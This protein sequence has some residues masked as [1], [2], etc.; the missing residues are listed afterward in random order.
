M[1]TPAE[2]PGRWRARA[3]DLIPYSTAAVA[4]FNEVAD[5]LEKALKEQAAELLT[6]NEAAEASGFSAD[7]LGVLIRQGKLANLG[8]KHSPRVRRPDLPRKPQ[9][10][11]SSSAAPRSKRGPWI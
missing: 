3:H 6:L 5:D 8:R 1:M 2:L 9:P 7:H 11:S 4:A 10:R